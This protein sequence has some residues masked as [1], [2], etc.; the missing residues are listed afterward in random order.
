MFVTNDFAAK[1]GGKNAPLP[2]SANVNPSPTPTPEP[3]DLPNTVFTRPDGK[4]IGLTLDNGVFKM[5]FYDENKNPVPA[6]VSRATV[7][8]MPKQKFGEE[9]S[10]LSVTGDGKAL[11]GNKYVQPPFPVH[12]NVVLLTAEGN[13]VE[14][15][16]GNFR[17]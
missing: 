5:S 8:W 17:P 6:D 12:V 9:T 4:L 7:R 15:Y 1:V 11:V 3:A 2:P 10:V 16:A 14:T 13:A